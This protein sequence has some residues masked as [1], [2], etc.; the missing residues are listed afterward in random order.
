MEARYIVNENGKRKG[1]ILP[2]ELYE[3]LIEEL[4]D[5]RAAEEAP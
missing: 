2:V 3:R 5:I 1:V 4:D